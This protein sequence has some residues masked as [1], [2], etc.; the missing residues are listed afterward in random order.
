MRIITAETWAI[1]KKSA[2]NKRFPRSTNSVNFVA[3]Q[4]MWPFFVL[5]DKNPATANTPNY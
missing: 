4:E 3:E 1:S 2:P 5:A